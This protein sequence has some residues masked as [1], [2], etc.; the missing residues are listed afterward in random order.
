MTTGRALAT[1]AGIVWTLVGVAAVI[2]IVGSVEFNR[3]YNQLTYNVG[4]LNGLD[5]GDILAVFAVLL[6]LCVVIGGAAWIVAA[7][8]GTIRN[9]RRR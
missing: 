3:G 4:L 2:A 5:L 8:V 1:V 9:F 7:A 6:G